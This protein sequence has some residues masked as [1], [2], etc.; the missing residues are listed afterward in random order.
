MESIILKSNSSTTHHILQVDDWVIKDNEHFVLMSYKDFYSTYENIHDSILPK[1]PMRLLKNILQGRK[2][3]Y[4]EDKDSVELEHNRY[5]KQGFVRC[6]EKSIEHIETFGEE[7]EKKQMVDFA[8]K[9]YEHISRLK[10][11]P[12][13]LI[14]ENKYLFEE[15]YDKTF[16]TPK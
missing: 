7:D 15:F 9:T 10:K 14:S 11:V 5:Y 3:T 16:N 2:A 13:N 4:L 8:L 6:L 1:T 12:E